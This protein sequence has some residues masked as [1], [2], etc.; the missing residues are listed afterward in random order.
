MKP[1]YNEGLRNLAKYV[2]S[3]NLLFCYYL[4]G[5]KI[6]F[7]TLY[8]I[9][10]RHST[11]EPFLE[12]PGN[13]SDSKANFN[14]QTCWKVARFLAH[15]PVNFA[16]LS[17]SFIVLFSILW[18]LWSNVNANTKNTKQFSWTENLPGLSRNRPLARYR[19]V[20]Y[21]MIPLFVNR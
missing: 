12:R 15:R 9:L 3:R 2:H 21:R 11:C 20:C 14:I 6:S 19:K 10:Y 17:D 5:W 16:S 13:F 7:V 4:V 1:R 8:I 18:K